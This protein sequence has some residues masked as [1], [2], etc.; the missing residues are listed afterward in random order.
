M[1]QNHAPRRFAAITIAVMIAFGL[2]AASCTNPAPPGGFSLKFR[3]KKIVNVS[4]KGD[5]PLT[6]AVKTIG[7][8]ETAHLYATHGNWGTQWAH[9]FMEP[10]GTTYYGASFGNLAPIGPGYWNSS[11]LA[12]PGGTPSLRRSAK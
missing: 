11:G 1:Y 3:A 9:S 7:P 5:Y 8:A 2:V 6:A 4:F 12:N 10:D